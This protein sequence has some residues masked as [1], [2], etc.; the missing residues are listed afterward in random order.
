MAKTSTTRPRRSLR[1]WPL[2]IIST[3]LWGLVPDLSPFGIMCCVALSLFGLIKLH[4]LLDYVNGRD[5]PGVADVISWFLFWPG[6]RPYT[7]FAVSEH[8]RQPKPSEWCFAGAKTIA[9]SL[10][11]GVVAPRVVQASELLA[12]WM[13][14]IGVVLVLHFGSF[15]LMALF[16][17]TRSRDVRP[18]MNSPILATSVNE[19]WS[20]RWN[21]AFRD[22]AHPFLFSPL[23]RL[24]SPVAAVVVGYVF[25]GLIHELAISVP[26]GRGFGLPTLY[27]VVQGAGILIE[28]AVEKSGVKL[29]GGVSGWIWTA[30]VVVPGAYI[31]FHP[32]FVRSVVVPLV[33]AIRFS[34]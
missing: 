29:R 27:F 20:S 23:A 3:G 25:S 6:L 2:M 26:A 8:V 4:I 9:G 1:W 12:G 30:L 18:I 22:Y 19:F 34:S 33:H 15:H 14:L 5:W 16:W 10:L 7:F 31:L 32:P 11:F 13:A 28:R 21:L 24:W 17:R